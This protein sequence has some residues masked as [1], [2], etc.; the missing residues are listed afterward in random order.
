MRWSRWRSS[1]VALLTAAAGLLPA[2]APALAAPVTCEDLR[3]PVTV[4]GTP[5]F[6]HGRLCTPAGASTVQVLIPGGTY[7]S[8]Y[9]DISYSPGTLSYRQAMNRAGIATL[10]VDRLGTG[11]SSRPLSALVTAS[12]QAHAVHQ[13]VRAVR[14]RFGKVVV[15]GHSIGAAMALIEAGT[16][17]DVDGVLVTGFTH[18]MNLV[19]VLPVLAGMIPA[20][21]DPGLRRG[22][23]DLG[24]LT[25]APG[26]RYKAFHAPGPRVP[27]AVGVDEA[28]KDVFSAAESVDTVTLHNVVIPFT[29][30]VDVP[31]MVVAGAGDTHFCGRP[32]GSDCT[33]ADALRASESPFFSPAARLQAYVLPDYG[34]SINYAPNAPT[35]HHAV[36]TWTTTL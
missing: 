36:T 4:L 9:W 25:T 17:R 20:V 2:P 15:G 13:V 34:H 16:Y 3:V 12:T 21:L 8:S 24:Y 23:L 35:Y 26:T 33:T 7:N 32:L 14:P 22:G 29:R 19:T 30:L 27:E 28:T 6:M 1:A 5:H 11:R 18:R 31:V 10:A